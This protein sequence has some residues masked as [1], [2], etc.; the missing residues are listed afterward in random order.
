MIEDITERK[1]AEE[2]LF[3]HAAIIGS[4]EDAIVSLSLD[5]VI[6]SW[7]P[8]AQRIF[9]YRESEAIGKLISSFVPPELP[10]EEEEILQKLRAGGRIDQFETVRIGKS[11]AR[12]D[13]SLD[14][15][16]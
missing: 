13:V 11:G 2:A 7:N 1:K 6:T 12:I 4:S 15:K 8:G 3:R 9:G 14:R 16:S 10:H 5:G